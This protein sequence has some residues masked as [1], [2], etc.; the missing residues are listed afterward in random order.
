MLSGDPTLPERPF[1]PR[2]PFEPRETVPSE[3]A[4]LPASHPQD[5]VPEAPAQEERA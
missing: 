1:P 3:D 2:R 5:Q 4:E